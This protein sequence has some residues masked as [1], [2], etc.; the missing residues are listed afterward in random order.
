MPASK[1]PPKIQ[2][3][4]DLIAA[5]LRRHYPVS[6]DDLAREV[7]QYADAEKKRDSI[8]RTFERDKDELRKAGVPIEAVADEFG[9]LTLYRLK[10][11]DFYLPYLCITEGGKQPPQPKRPRGQGYQSLPLLAF[12]PDELALV[13]RAANRVQQMGHPALAADAATAVRKLAFDVAIFDGDVREVLMAPRRSEDSSVLDIVSEAVRRRKTLDFTYHSMERDAV[14]S[15]HVEPFGLVFLSGNWY[16]IARD[17]SADALRHFRVNRITQPVINPLRTQSVDF[18]VP[19]DFDIWSHADSRQAWELGN[20]DEI[21]V[22]VR[23]TPIDVVAV[24][25]AQLGEPD[26]ELPDCRQFKVRRPE[27]FARWLLSLAGSATPLAPAS[28][29]AKWRTMAAQTAA[30]YD[31]AQ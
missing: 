26:A 13:A 29:V 14:A 9:N 22:R 24:S 23:F 19:T 25:A 16:L 27:A 31:E 15:R 5:L 2:R 6:F 20:D 12:E 21:S 8:L 17:P 28:M 10:S 7:P 30:L 18:E 4:F 11:R 1:R 3:W